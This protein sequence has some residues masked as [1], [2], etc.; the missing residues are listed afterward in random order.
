MLLDAGSVDR[1]GDLEVGVPIEDLSMPAPSPLGLKSSIEYFAMSVGI[2]RTLY[3]PPSRLVLL[4]Q[5][6]EKSPRPMTIK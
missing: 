6:Y 5:R 4:D 2:G 1:S 3:R